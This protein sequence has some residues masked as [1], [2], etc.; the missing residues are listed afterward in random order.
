MRGEYQENQCSGV[1]GIDDVL[2]KTLNWCLRLHLGL[3]QMVYR[4][5]DDDGADG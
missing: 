3:A 1:K 5:D 4:D 2:L